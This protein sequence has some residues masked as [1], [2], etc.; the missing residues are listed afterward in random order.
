MSGPD[1]TTPGN[2][3]WTTRT[4]PLMRQV[5]IH[6]AKIQGMGKLYSGRKKKRQNRSEGVDQGSAEAEIEEEGEGEDGQLMRLFETTQGSVMDDQETLFLESSETVSTYSHSRM[7][8]VARGSR[9]LSLD[10]VNQAARPEVARGQNTSQISQQP[11][12]TD[13]FTRRRT[14]AISN[15]RGPTKRQ[16]ENVPMARVARDQR[17]QVQPRG[18]SARDRYARNNR[19]RRGDINRDRESRRWRHRQRTDLPTTTDRNR[20]SGSGFGGLGGRNA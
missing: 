19:N 4:D 10:Q 1:D 6:G 13:L 8:R 11:A 14:A 12:T 15:V 2:A 16:R 17:A 9:A 18:S 3:T 5:I 20:R 7:E